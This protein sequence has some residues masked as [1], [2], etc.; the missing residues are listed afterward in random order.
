MFNASSPKIRKLMYS[1]LT[2]RWAI[3]C[4]SAIACQQ[5]IEATSTIWLV[6]MMANITSGKN[7]FPNLFLYLLSIAL[8]YI[9]NGIA[10][11]LKTTWKQQ[12]QRSFI[13][14]FVASNK[15]NIGEWSNKGLK[16]EKLSM[17]TAEGPAAINALIDYVWDL[18]VFVFSVVFNILALSIIVEPLFA[19][20]YAIS[21]IC[22]LVVM[23]LKRR[24]QRQLTQKALTAR[25]DL[26]QSLFA[27][28]DN[29]LLG[30]FYNFN[31]W[32][33]KTDQRL[34]RCLQRNVALERF[35]QFLAIFVSL[36]TSIPSLLVV[37]Y[38][39]IINRHDPVRLSAFVVILPLLF[40]IL[41]YTYQ[42]LSLIFRWSMHHSK[43]A[44]IYKTIQAAKDLHVPLLKKVKWSKINVQQ[45]IIRDEAVPS[46]DHIPLSAQQSLMSYNDLLA[47][48]TQSGR[49]TIRGENG[50]GK[51]TA[52]LLVK[53]ALSKKAF[54]LP[55]HNQLSF[56]AE[57][58]KYST[59]ESLRNRLLEI[60]EQVDA[61]V[62]L[63]DEWDAN[64]D[65]ENKEKLHNLIN[66]LAT[67][68]CVIEVRHR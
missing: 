17:L 47:F 5:I 43:L 42:M 51:S 56:H 14:A 16:E 7:F 15:N 64:L 10:F 50:C 29:V 8:F 37:A 13:H 66:E 62:L 41:S 26:C 67:T 18:G 27:S 45:T 12:A 48:T 49:V 39:M 25:V 22:V 60:L 65:S 20:A 6:N 36:V 55:T 21:L 68:K 19:V 44:A 40:N 35:D 2:N 59:G 3:G 52:L 28:W 57:T 31:I 4:L 53:N 54:F 34:D 61:D 9:P 23:K 32:Q 30:N 63:L 38:F 24:A 1:L 58:N 33:E 11:I 46:S